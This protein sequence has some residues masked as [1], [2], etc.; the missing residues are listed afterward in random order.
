LFPRDERRQFKRLGDSRAADLSRGH[1]GKHKVAA[2]QC[3]TKDRPGMALRSRRRSSPGPR[4]L[5]ESRA[6]LMKRHAGLANPRARG[7][8]PTPLVSRGSSL[9]ILIARPK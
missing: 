4:Q 9:V 3:P 1:L 8:S 2:F 6:R 5:I 7:R